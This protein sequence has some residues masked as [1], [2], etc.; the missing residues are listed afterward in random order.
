MPE[1][2][3]RHVAIVLA[4]G[5]SRRLG[6]PKQ[7][8]TR[9]GETLLRRAVRLAQSTAPLQTVVVLG[10]DHERLSD[11]LDGLDCQCVINPAW[12]SGIAGSLATAAAAL[13]GHEGPTLVVGC[14]QPA[15][16]SAHLHALLQGAASA[17]SRCAA[18][19]H[20]ELPGIPVVVPKHW[21]LGIERG[22]GDSGLGP[23]IRGL[24]RNRVFALDAPELR[25]DVD[26]GDDVDD[27]IARGWLDP[28]NA[29]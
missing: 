5:G 10:A 20:G 17:S 19:M 6:R 4:A 14:D 22:D 2:R 8:L 23:R 27:A 1:Y 21:L 28:G 3:A 24:S 13:S 9:D 12:Q 26:T 29:G 18:T 15:L 25:F 11:V 7:L 16:S